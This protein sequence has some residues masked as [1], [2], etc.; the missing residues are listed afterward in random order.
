MELEPK[1]AKLIVEN[2]KDIIK[3]EINLFDTS[4]TI[5][6]STDTSRIGTSHQGAKLVAKSQETIT[7]KQD[8]QYLGAKKGINI[9]VLFNQSVIAIIGITGEPSEVEPLGNIIK[10]MTEILIRENYIQITQFHQRQNFHN[11]A[12]MLIAPKRD[13]SLVAYL[14][15]LLDVDL[16]RPR[17]IVVGKLH[18][19]ENKEVLDYEELLHTIQLHLKVYSTSFFSLANQ[20]V[21][22][23]IDQQAEASLHNFLS[24]LQNDIAQQFDRQISFGIGRCATSFHDY[25]H[26]YEE[27]KKTI[28]WMIHQ[29]EATISTYEEM[30]YG[31]LFVDISKE[32]SQQLQKRVLGNL[33]EEEIDQ[34]QLIFDT[35]EHFNG[36][37]MRCAEALFLHKNTFQNR[38]NRLADKTGYNPRKL[39]DFTILSAAFMSHH[40]DQS[41]KSS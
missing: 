21:C 38:L 15:S 34:Y 18:T 10:K 8:D 39:K 24:Q 19:H 28:K 36:S 25:W 14:A 41:A 5:V 37:I 17:R 11:L 30:D 23:F 4:G 7:I 40:L 16:E 12:N 27:A 26:S 6:A 20:E 13:N 9:P 31:L 2:L 35:Y 33:T 22:L 1:V 32:D 29:F 3:H